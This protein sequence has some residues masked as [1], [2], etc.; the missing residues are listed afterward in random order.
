MVTFLQSEQPLRNTDY[1]SA[2]TA[3]K[4]TMGSFPRCF[5]GIEHM[6][7]NQGGAQQQLS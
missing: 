2:V 3:G 7:G 5:S 1:N 6:V 4:V